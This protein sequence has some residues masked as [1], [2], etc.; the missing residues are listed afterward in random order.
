MSE[1][2]PFRVTRAARAYDR[3]EKLPVSVLLDNIRSMYNVG[4]V[5]R[6]ADGAGVESLYLSG[7]TARPPK[8]EITKTALGAEESVPW[9]GSEDALATVDA[10]R[11]RGYEI[12]AIETAVTAVDLFDWQPRWP[13]LLLFGHEV[14]GLRP[15]LMER[16]DTLVCLPM[17]GQKYSLNVASAASIVLYELLRKYRG[18]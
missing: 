9:Q 16:C 17:L 1:R 5:F 14:E 2:T 8:K 15:E 12:A 11:G 10:L 4:S 3:I 18:A 13:V 7:I 6:S